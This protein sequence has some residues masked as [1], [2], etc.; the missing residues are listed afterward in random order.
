MLTDLRNPTQER[1]PVHK[2]RLPTRN[3]SYLPFTRHFVTTSDSSGNS[4][5]YGT[6]VSTVVAHNLRHYYQGSLIMKLPEAAGVATV[7]A[8]SQFHPI[9]LAANAAGS[10]FATNYLRKLM[11]GK[12]VEGGTAYMQKLC[13]YDWQPLQSTDPTAAKGASLYHGRDARPGI[14]RIH[15][16]FKPERVW[17]AP[18]ASRPGGGERDAEGGSTVQV[19]LPEELAVTAMCWNKSEECSSWV[20]IGWGSGLVRVMDLSHGVT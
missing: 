11:P 10:V 19:V 2:S 1:I 9:I 13:E 14:S 4:E 7:L 3:M 15:E 12:R 20:A 18:K 16:G 6:T 5:T 8:T 17:V